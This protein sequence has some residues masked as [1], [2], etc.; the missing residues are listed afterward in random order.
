MGNYKYLSIE[1]KLLKFSPT[2]ALI[3]QNKGV[4]DV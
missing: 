4:F 3:H 2:I 1:Y